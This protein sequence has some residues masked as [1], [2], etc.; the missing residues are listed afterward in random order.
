MDQAMEMGSSYGKSSYENQEEK[1]SKPDRPFKPDHNTGYNKPV[2][3]GSWAAEVKPQAQAGGPNSPWKFGPC[4]YCDTGNH[5][6]IECLIVKSKTPQEHILFKVQ[7]CTN[8]F[9]Q[10]HTN[11]EGG[12]K[13]R[14]RICQGPH[15]FVLHVLVENQNQT[16]LPKEKGPLENGG[17]CLSVGTKEK[18]KV[19]NTRP[20]D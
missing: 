5:G 18:R 12:T 14:C 11:K 8:C 20:I 9:G 13:K 1:K 16:L 10:R 4:D 19:M 7:K 2:P 15:H 3:K 17:M 6:Y